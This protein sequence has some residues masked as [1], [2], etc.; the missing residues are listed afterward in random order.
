MA[1]RIYITEGIITYSVKSENINNNC[2]LITIK[3]VDARFPS[4]ITTI[5]PK[6]NVR[7]YAKAVIKSWVK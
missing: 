6:D 3:M 5:T 2:T 7:K 1:K 4:W